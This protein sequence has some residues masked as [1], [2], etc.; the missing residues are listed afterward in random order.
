MGIRQ[1][2]RWHIPAP[3]C[4]KY[5]IKA[6]DYLV[7][8]DGSTGEFIIKDPIQGRIVYNKQIDFEDLAYLA[9]N[10]EASE[11]IQRLQPKKQPSLG[12]GYNNHHIILH[13]LWDQCEL[14]IRAERY[15]V[16]KKDGNENLM[17][18]PD[19]FH[20]K[21]HGSSS[22]Y[23]RTLRK[24]LE[25]RWNQLMDAGLDEDPDAIREALLEIIE[26]I[27]QELTS[28]LEEEGKTI[29]NFYMRDL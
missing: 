12:G 11:A 25:K 3:I 22:P 15:G 10:K 5:N 4:N 23:S 18:L 2:S 27:R 26:F 9:P 6:G 14:T 29:R 13:D 17:P 21:N 16:L 7:M 20:R 19:E 24:H 8:Y 28:L 1:W